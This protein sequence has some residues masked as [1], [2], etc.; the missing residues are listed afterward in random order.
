MNNLSAYLNFGLKFFESYFV[1]YLTSLLIPLGFGVLGAMF[2]F[3]T[4]QNPAFIV[5]GLLS[6]PLVCYAFWRG[7]LVT[8]SLNYAA[9]AKIRQEN[10]P[11]ENF[12]IMTKEKE[13]ELAS[14][15]GFCAIISIIGF[16]P[17]IIFIIKLLTGISLHSIIYD[18]NAI[19][20]V[21]MILIINSIV[22][23]PFFNFLNQAFFFKKENESYF[24]LVFNCYKK[25][26]TKGLILCIIFG[27]T[28]GI[29]SLLHPLV[30]LILALVL[31]V[32]A[33]SI[34]TLWY[35]QRQ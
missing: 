7:Y 24:S 33:F 16:L 22:L 10:K 20:K 9:L 14:Y 8:Y 13:K 28:S 6:I 32:F 23:L 31:N 35:S 27:V 2:L 3:L 26:D 12:L 11:L 17:G 25:L 34:N 1:Q 4:M 29:I 21:F 5:L 19:I 18:M 15:L 30:Y